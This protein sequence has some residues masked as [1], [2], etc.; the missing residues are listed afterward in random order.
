MDDSA[1]PMQEIQSLEHLPRNLL[2]D[3]HRNSLVIVP[4][5]DLQQVAAE[6]LK[7]HAKM[8]TI[9]S[10]MNE[11]IEQSHNMRVVS[12]LPPLLAMRDL[13]D[14][15]QDLHLIEGCL[16]VMRRTFL[17][18]YGYICAIFEVL[19]QPDCRKVAPA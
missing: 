4:L 1:D 9:L 15:L 16:H 14:L 13:L 17:D 18:F 19:T 6:Y 5:D 11:S 2:T 7:N 10:L 8:I 3:I 12:A